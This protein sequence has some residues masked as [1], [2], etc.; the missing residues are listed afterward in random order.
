MILGDSTERPDP[1]RLDI[2]DALYTK[3]MARK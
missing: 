3:Q 2:Y 1:A